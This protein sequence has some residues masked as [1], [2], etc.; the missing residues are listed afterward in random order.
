M[1]GCPGLLS[2]GALVAAHAY[3]YIYIYILHSHKIS[4]DRGK[5]NCCT[6]FDKRNGLFFVSTFYLNFFNIYI[7]TIPVRPVYI[8][9]CTP[10]MKPA[11]LL[12]RGQEAG[13]S[14]ISWLVADCNWDDEGLKYEV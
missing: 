14:F 1:L 4:I 5:L 7:R 9:F 6:F 8:Y 3:I 2:A 11:F 12:Y 10:L 13:F